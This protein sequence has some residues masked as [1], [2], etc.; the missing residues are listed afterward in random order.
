MCQG[1]PSPKPTCS[2]RGRRTGHVSSKAWS[3]ADAGVAEY[4]TVDYA[5]RYMSEPVRA[6]RL[7]DGGW[8]PW[9]I[10]PAGRWESVQ[11]G[12]SVAFD[13]LYLRIYD[14]EGRLQPLP[15]EVGGLLRKQRSQLADR[16]A[17]LTRLRA[18]AEAGDLAAVRALLQD[19]HE[20]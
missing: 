5:R 17:L 7:V 12:V 16:D 2:A 1:T 18:L 15:H 11:L 14:A 6:L 4:I 13:G 10:S 8:A 9:P 20:S 3:Y 19:P